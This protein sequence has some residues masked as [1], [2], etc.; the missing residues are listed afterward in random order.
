MPSQYVINATTQVFKQTVP[1][2]LDTTQSCIISNAGNAC[3]YIHFLPVRNAFNSLKLNTITCLTSP[4]H[5]FVHVV[6][7][8]FSCLYTG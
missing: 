3:H 2:N 6:Y 5:I 8:R 4:L 1:D 7:R